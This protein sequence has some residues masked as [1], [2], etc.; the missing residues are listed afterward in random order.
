M[1]FLSKL[2]GGKKEEPKAE[3][4]AKVVSEAVNPASVWEPVTVKKYSSERKYGFLVGKSGEKDIF[5]HVS[6]LQRCGLA[7]LIEGQKCEV[8][9]KNASKGRE[10]VEIRVLK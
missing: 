3:S 1:G 9:C 4:E 2:F 7:S 6:T 5:V 8:R 10:A